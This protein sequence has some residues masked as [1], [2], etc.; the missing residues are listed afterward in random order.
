MGTYRHIGFVG[1][2][3]PD[4]SAYPRIDLQYPLLYN[5]YVL[6]ETWRLATGLKFAE[7][8]AVINY[9]TAQGISYLYD[10][11]PTM[12][13]G[14]GKG[15]FDHVVSLLR[16]KVGTATPPEPPPPV[17]P[18]PEEPLPP[19]PPPVAPITDDQVV[20]QPGTFR[21]DPTVRDTEPGKQPP[22]AAAGQNGIPYGTLAI[23]AG[24]GLL[25]G[26]LMRRRRK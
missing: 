24:A 16:A 21:I 20:I 7:Q 11:T 18:L 8:Q 25:L 26:W 23:M 22:A 4:L 12:F 2:D 19:Q 15:Q 5:F 17:A 6:W 14:L 3:P 9:L 1:A 13:G 10:Y